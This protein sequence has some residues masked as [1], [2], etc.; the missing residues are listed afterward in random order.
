MNEQAETPG[1]ASPPAVFAR[2]GA[3]LVLVWL[4][5]GVWG[6]LLAL[7]DDVR[8]VIVPVVQVAAGFT[9]YGLRT[10]PV[11]LRWRALLAVQAAALALIGGLSAVSLLTVLIAG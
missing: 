10:E 4:A 9:I 7:H 8:G 6:Y 11:L 1:G 5:L 3:L 2:L